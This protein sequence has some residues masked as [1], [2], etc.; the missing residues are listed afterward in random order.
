MRVG[1]VS[2]AA[3]MPYVYNTNAVNR[4][5]MNKI[6]PIEDDLL[7][8]KTGFESSEENENMNPL[9]VGETKDFGTILDMQMQ[10]GMQNAARLGL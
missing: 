5:S 3:P 10:M 8:S 6:E 4:A 9:A 7:S 2:M 1:A